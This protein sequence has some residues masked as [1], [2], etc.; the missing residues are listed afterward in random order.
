[1]FRFQLQDTSLMFNYLKNEIIRKDV[2][3]AVGTKLLM[4]MFTA[5]VLKLK[6][7]R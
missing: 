7:A 5:I 6:L 4:L 2:L 1:M 3:V